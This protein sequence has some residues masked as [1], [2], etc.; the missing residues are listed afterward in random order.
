MM[1]AKGQAMHVLE[2]IIKRLCYEKLEYSYFTYWFTY[3][4]NNQNLKQSEVV[5]RLFRICE[6]VENTYDID[7]WARLLFYSD[8]W[9]ILDKYDHKK[10]FDLYSR[11]RLKYLLFDKYC[12]TDYTRSEDDLGRMVV[13]NLAVVL[14]GSISP[15]K[16]LLEFQDE[17]DYLFDEPSN[18]IEVF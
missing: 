2:E 4:L 14:A 16:L 8:L 1:V 7:S 15:S 6:D 12:H 13:S 17:L 18:V 10:A 3:F 5:D 11:F 9:E